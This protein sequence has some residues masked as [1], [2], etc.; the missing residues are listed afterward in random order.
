M[1]EQLQRKVEQSVKFLQSAC[2][3]KQVEL[4]YSGGK[5]SDVILELAKMAGIDFVPIYKDTTI[6]PPGTKAHCREKGV[7]IRKPPV[8]FMQC[9]ERGGFP[10]RFRRHCCDHLKEYKIMDHAIQGIRRSEST[11]R[12]AR[13]TEPTM[14]RFYGSKKNH[15]EVFMP[16]LEWSADDVADFITEYNVKCHPLYY[17]DDGTFHVERRLGCLCCPLASRKKR[18]E[19][20]KKYPNMLK[21]YIL[22]GGKFFAKHPNSKILTYFND[23]YEWLLFTL[24]CDKLQEFDYKFGVYGAR[25]DCKAILERMFNTKL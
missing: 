9:I 4:C 20:F 17:D 21:Y 10:S 22:G 16:I 1:N 8:T 2:R 12:A 15:V 3:G 24:T 14:C 13:Y 18:I 7:E 11:A 23:P 19:E 25:A 5:D 6:D